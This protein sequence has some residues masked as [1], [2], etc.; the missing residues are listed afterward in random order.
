MSSHRLGSRGFAELLAGGDLTA[1]MA[2]KV[3]LNLETALDSA[4]DTILA[5]VCSKCRLIIVEK[6]DTNASLYS[7]SSKHQP[8]CILVK[9]KGISDGAVELTINGKST[10]ATLLSSLVEEIKV[11]ASASL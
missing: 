8:L 4:F 9:L 3:T 11:A 1:K 6:V 7:V 2:A 10:S 5:S